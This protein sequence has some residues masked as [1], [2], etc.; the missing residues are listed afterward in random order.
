MNQPKHRDAT[1][2][3]HVLGV[4]IKVHSPTHSRQLIGYLH[5][6][7]IDPAYVRI[8]RIENKLAEAVFEKHNADWR[9][10]RLIKTSPANIFYCWL[11]I[12]MKMPLMANR[13]CM[14]YF[15]LIV[16]P[17]QVKSQIFQISKYSDFIPGTCFEMLN[18]YNRVWLLARYHQQSAHMR[19]MNHLQNQIYQHG[20]F[21]TH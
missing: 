8:L 5:K 12:A 16:I 9:C 19:Q 2:N 15:S 3:G 18:V 4:G 1:E 17:K 20:Q 21:I 11:Q 14:L 13:H 10:T 7:D 6:L